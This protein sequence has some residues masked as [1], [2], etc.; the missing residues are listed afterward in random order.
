MAA[1]L[2]K[3]TGEFKGFYDLEVTDYTIEYPENDFCIKVN[4]K[5]KNNDER[6]WTSNSNDALG[7]YKMLEFRLDDPEALEPGETTPVDFLSIASGETVEIDDNKDYI[8]II[9]IADS[10]TLYFDQVIGKNRKN[11]LT[12]PLTEGSTATGVNTINTDSNADDNCYT[13]KGIR[14]ATP[15]RAGV[16]IKNK[17]TLL[18]K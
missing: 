7:I 4:I 18:I 1:Y 10:V 9:P 16:Y 15:K 13:L 2:I 17:K 12:V 11:L 5:I 6:D 8:D 14:I 3:V